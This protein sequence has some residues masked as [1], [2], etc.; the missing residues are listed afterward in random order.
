MKN[1][2]KFNIHIYICVCVCG[3]I[4]SIYQLPKTENRVYN[5]Y[6]ICSEKASFPCVHMC[7]PELGA[8]SG[9][10][11]SCAAALFRLDALPLHSDAWK[12]INKPCSERRKH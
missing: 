2:W 1:K 6:N 5:L 9:T 7:S 11:R 3:F 8:R 4:Y 12:V 10:W